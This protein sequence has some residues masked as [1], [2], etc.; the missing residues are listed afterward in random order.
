M[1]TW[2]F[3]L[4]LLPAVTMATPV[5]EYQGTLSQGGEAVS[6]AVSFTFYIYD[7]EAA[8][9]PIWTETH[10]EIEVVDGRFSVALFSHSEIAAEEALVAA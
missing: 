10:E 4:L 6:R 2:I 1:K 8:E 7:D 3:L 9:L 5:V